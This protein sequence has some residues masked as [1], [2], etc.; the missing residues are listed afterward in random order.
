MLLMA[1]VNQAATNINTNASV[2]ASN[3][4]TLAGAAAAAAGAVSSSSS[5]WL[6]PMGEADNAAAAGLVPVTYQLPTAAQLQH[7]LQLGTVG[8]QL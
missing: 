6:V 3:G 7:K 4:D 1:P 2:P 5:F 8:P